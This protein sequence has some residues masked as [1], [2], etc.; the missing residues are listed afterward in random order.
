M[1]N[2][3]QLIEHLLKLDAT[4]PVVYS[5]YS[6]YAVLDLCDIELKKLCMPRADGWVQDYREDYEHM[7]YVTFP[8]N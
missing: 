1:A 6:E 4:L 2:V 8:G 5:C 7:V 3:A